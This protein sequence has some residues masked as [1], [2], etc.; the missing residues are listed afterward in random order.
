MTTAQ[1]EK[2]M[3]I[4]HGATGIEWVRQYQPRPGGSAGHFASRAEEYSTKAIQCLMVGMEPEALELL[5][6]SDEW[7]TPA[8]ARAE[9][10]EAFEFEYEHRFH[11]AVCQWLFGRPAS[12]NN[13]T[14]AC[15]L[16]D[17]S[18]AIS[19]ARTGSSFHLDLVLPL[20]LAAGRYTECVLTYDQSG[21]KYPPPR[22]RQHSEAAMACLLA[23]ERLNPSMQEP[24]L[25]KRQHV[26]LKEQ[27]SKLLAS[28]QEHRFAL[29][30]QIITRA[31]AGAPARAAIRQVADQ[32]A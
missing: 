29:W 15:Q 12:A 3:V 27:V 8:L 4:L 32:Y 2:L 20:W 26:F 22:K 28:G 5:H 7:L 6:Q 24:D 30:V 25:Q 14:R 18:G 10:G 19:S 16:L 11:H 21:A 23:H 9:A 13:L 17:V 1:Y 31:E